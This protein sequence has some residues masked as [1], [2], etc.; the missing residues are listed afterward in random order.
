[1]ILKALIKK[2]FLITEERVVSR[3]EEF[4]SSK[5]VS[6]SVLNEEQQQAFKEIHTVFEQKKCC[7][8]HGVTHKL[9]SLR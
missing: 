7:L 8:L 9:R 2:G 5:M 1:M 3:L 4:D 6:K